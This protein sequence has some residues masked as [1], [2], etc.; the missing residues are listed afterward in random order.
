M[1]DNL[2]V[3]Y[4]N[5]VDTATTITASSTASTTNCNVSNLKNDHKYKIWRSVGD[6]LETLSLTFTPSIVGGLI[7]PYCNLSSEA[8]ISVIGTYSSIT[9][10]N[11][12]DQLCCPYIP[13]GQWHWGTMPLGVNSYA[14]G[15]STCARIWFPTQEVLDSITITIKDPNN[16]NGYIEASRLVLGSYWSPKYNTSFGLSTNSSELSEHSRTESGELITN[17]GAKFNSMTFELNYMTSADRLDLM[18]IV[19]GNGMPTPLFISLF[20]NSA[21]VVKEQTHQIYGKLMQIPGVVHNIVDMYST[22]IEI[23][24]V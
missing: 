23:G 21:D 12:I 6:T 13:L 18:N 4:K 10:V 15:G 5:I 1:G 8:T 16:T 22:S 19:K 11:I 20:P 3:I 24:E 17:R 2:R 7:L 14:Y 9:K